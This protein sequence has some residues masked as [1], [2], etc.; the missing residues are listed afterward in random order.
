MT[1]RAVAAAMNTM[2]KDCICR[3]L[4]VVNCRDL[5]YSPGLPLHAPSFQEPSLVPPTSLYP[6]RRLSLSSLALGPLDAEEGHALSGLGG[7]DFQFPII[8]TQP[9]FLLGHRLKATQGLD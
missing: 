6:L 8:L 1:A 5:I 9:P 4:L 3:S 2:R 7:T